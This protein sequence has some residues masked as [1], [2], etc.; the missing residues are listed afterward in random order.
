MKSETSEALALCG[1]KV[2]INAADRVVDKPDIRK[3][4]HE[5]TERDTTARR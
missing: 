5:R 1:L 3:H 4:V 2:G